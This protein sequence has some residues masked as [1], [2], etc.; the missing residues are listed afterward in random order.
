M[1]NENQPDRD[2]SLDYHAA[3]VL[4]LIQAFSAG[5]RTG[6]DG[7]TKLAKLD[8]LVRY[9][10]MMER[11]SDELHVPTTNDVEP[12]SE[13]R[14]AVESRMIR[15]KYGPWDDRYYP[16]LGMLLGLG[17]VRAVPGR[18]K[19]KVVTTKSGREIASRISASASWRRTVSRCT[20]AAQHF[21]V[22]GSQ[23]KDLIYKSLP[24]AVD[25]PHR[26]LI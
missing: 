25:R 17:L 24:D 26:T 11:L 3:R 1:P 22:T 8:F 20:F 14:L 13:E 5:R 19:I 2:S 16:I 12:T 4:L 23:L 18:G 15:Y 9:P 10:V 6:I 21:D 7:L